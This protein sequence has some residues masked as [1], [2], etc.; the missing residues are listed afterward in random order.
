MLHDKGNCYS[1]SFICSV[2]RWYHGVKLF[3]F[4]SCENSTLL[5][6]FTLHFQDCCCWLPHCSK[7]CCSLI[8]SQI[9]NTILNKLFLK[10]LQYYFYMHTSMVNGIWSTA[11]QSSLKMI[12]SVQTKMTWS[13]FTAIDFPCR[14]WSDAFTPCTCRYPSFSIKR[15]VSSAAT[16]TSTDLCPRLVRLGLHIEPL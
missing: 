5:I 6:F 13:D 1:S 12:S 11:D 14:G 10:Q 7:T 9:G 15:R 8:R 3:I 4:V 16:N 2:N